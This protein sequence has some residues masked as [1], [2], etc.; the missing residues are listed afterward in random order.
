MV[1]ANSN[2]KKKVVGMVAAVCAATMAVAG[3]LALFTDTASIKGATTAGKLA[4][5]I[6]ADKMT[7]AGVYHQH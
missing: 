5:G 1:N 3:S 7:E 6:T 4:I 2:G